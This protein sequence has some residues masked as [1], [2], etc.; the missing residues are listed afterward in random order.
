MSYFYYA[1]SQKP[2]GVSHSA[3]GS[4]TAAGDLNLILAKSSRLELYKITPEG[5]EHMYE[6]SLYG[7]ISTMRTIRVSVRAFAIHTAII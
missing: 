2:T 3:V 6:T 4:F 7:R 1:T 5:L